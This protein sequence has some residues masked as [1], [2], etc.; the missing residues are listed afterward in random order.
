VVSGINWQGFAFG[1]VAGAV[2]LAFLWLYNLI[3]K[4]NSNLHLS[5]LG[6]RYLLTAPNAA[7]QAFAG[8]KAPEGW[9]FCDGRTLSR[10][11]E[12]Q[13]FA[14]IGVKF[15]GGDGVN[16]FN[17]PYLRG[18]A[19]IGAGSFPGLTNRAFGTRIGSETTT[20][21]IGTNPH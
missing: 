10:V 17:V 13:L 19:I 20:L 2:I 14:V 3:A 11:K 7:I 1:I 4:L 12:A 18:H 9:T 21:S 8:D 15:G 5:T 6:L 16:T